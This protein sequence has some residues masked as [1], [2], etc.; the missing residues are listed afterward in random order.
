MA[1][2]VLPRPVPLL[3]NSTGKVKV[4]SYVDVLSKEEKVGDSVAVIGAGGIGFDVSD[5][6][7]HGHVAGHTP[8]I[9][10]DKETPN[11]DHV[12]DTAVDQFL[13]DWGVDKK[14]INS[15]GLIPKEEQVTPISPRKVY[16]LQRKAGRLGR[17]L[18]K[19]TGWIHRSTLK[20]RKVEEIGSCKYVEVNDEGLVIEVKDKQGQVQRRT[21]P[22]DTVV[23]CAGQESY[24]PLHT[25]LSVSAKDASVDGKAPR[26]FLIGGAQEAGELDAKRA[27]DQGTRLAAVIE[28]AKT[29]DVYEARHDQSLMVKAMQGMMKIVQ[30]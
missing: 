15:G 29:G 10:S 24:K 8:S 7:T 22:V 20:K 14:I 3:N 23:L 27:I 17:G 19:T 13:Q 6:L 26:F 16:L 1:T 28:E 21:L 5:F 11:L 9:P 12:D 4:L 25:A 2:G 30:R 18:G